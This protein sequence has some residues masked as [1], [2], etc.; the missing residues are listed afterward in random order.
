MTTSMTAGPQ[1]HVIAW[2][3]NQVG[4]LS[5]T[6]GGGF[7]VAIILWLGAC[8]VGLWMAPKRQWRWPI[9]AVVIG[10]AFFWFSAQDAAIFGGVATDVNSLVPIAVMAWCASPRLVDAPPLVRRMPKEMRSGTGAVL[11][12]FSAAMIVFSVVS[13]GF[14]SAASAENTLYVAQNGPASSV[15]TVA[16]GFTLIDQSGVKYSI[17][18]H[19]GHYT[20]LTFLDPVCWTDCPL[21]AAQLASVRSSLSASAKLDIVS[22]AADPYHETL[23]NVNHF[24]AIHDLGHVK[25]FYFVTDSDVATVRKVW[26]SYGIGVS[27]KPT[28]KMS[29]HSDYM[30]II[31]PHGRLRWIIPD[32]PLSSVSGQSSAESQILSLLHGLGVR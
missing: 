28:D 9:R 26:N 29:I 7:N 16:P 2:F 22:V 17:N 6:M 12:A 25:G 5:G 23:A 18:E 11:A 4:D 24:I 3:A 21:L 1:P 10:A 19:A 32:D 27:M 31:D 13:M 30:F 8:A 15:N 20:L 14:A